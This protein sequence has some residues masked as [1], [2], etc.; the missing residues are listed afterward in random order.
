MFCLPAALYFRTLLFHHQP[1]TFTSDALLYFRAVPIC[2][3]GMGSLLF[4][5]SSSVLL[6]PLCLHF[7][8]CG[9]VQMHV[10][11]CVDHSAYAM[12]T[13]MKQNHVYRHD[14]SKSC[15]SKCPNLSTCYIRDTIDIA[16]LS[17]VHELEIRQVE[18][19]QRYLS[20]KS[21]SIQ[22][23]SLHPISIKSW[24]LPQ[25]S[26]RHWEG[27]ISTK[28]QMVYAMLSTHGRPWV[29]TSPTWEWRASCG[30]SSLKFSFT[31]VSYCEI[32]YTFR[33]ICAK[34]NGS[35]R[36][37]VGK[38]SFLFQAIVAGLGGK[39]DGSAVDNLLLVFGW[40]K[41]FSKKKRISESTNSSKVRG[42]PFISKPKHFFGG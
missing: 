17:Q 3:F 26:P 36:Q 10:W 19:L 37:M 32:L 27:G 30:Q 23:C 34:V 31:P 28:Q 11:M 18:H 6:L 20:S 15:V 33:V 41:W 1:F 8:I 14:T 39:V 42:S 35:K 29:K 5:R 9:I 12:Y 13:S 25:N 21:R 24:P 2:L 38:W 4:F 16:R 40:G 7:P 22:N